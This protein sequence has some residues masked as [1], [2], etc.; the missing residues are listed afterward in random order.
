MSYST[1][2]LT[3]AADC[4]LLIGLANKVEG[5]LEFRKLSLQR[6]QTS[7]TE[8]SVEVNSELDAVTAELTA[9]TS[10]IASLPDGTNKEEQITK[11][12]KAELKQ[13]LLSQKKDEY[14]SVALLNKE[15][16]LGRIER[17]LEET[18]TFITALE[19]RK[20]AIG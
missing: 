11:K 14:G 3:T 18:Q 19:E 17:E 15:Y 10:I 20:T 7:Y 6:Q 12:K 13:Y 5:D 2:L 4:D 16:E 8:N 9:L 1:A